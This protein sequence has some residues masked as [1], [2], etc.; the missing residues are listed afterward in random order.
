MLVDIMHN[1]SDMAGQIVKPQNDRVHAPLKR[2]Y[3]SRLYPNADERRSEH[4]PVK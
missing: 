2:D 1:V 3:S 4:E